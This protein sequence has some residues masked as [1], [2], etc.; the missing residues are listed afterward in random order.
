[1]KIDLF[2][3]NNYNYLDIDGPLEFSHDVYEG[4]G[5]RDIR[6]VRVKGSIR[7]NSVDEI[8]TELEVSGIFILPCAVSLEDVSYN[9]KTNIDEIVGNFND[10]YDNH[11]N[12]LDI[13]PF[14]WENIVSEVPIRVVKDGI[15]MTNNSGDGWELVSE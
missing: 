13:S 6:N 11:Q 8:E 7:I 3:L 15:N 4:M 12:T 14:L 2:K 1:M 5:V 10:F 9:F